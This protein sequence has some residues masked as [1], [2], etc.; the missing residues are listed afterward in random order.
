[1]SVRI[2]LDTNI[3]VSYFIGRNFDEVALTILNNNLTVFSCS[4][5]ED[6][7][8]DVLGRAKFKKLIRLDIERYLL[9]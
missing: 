9:F 7:V 1:M 4:E 6:E 2:I 3:W 8:V 5:L